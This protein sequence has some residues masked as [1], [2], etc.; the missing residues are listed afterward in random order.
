MAPQVTSAVSPFARLRAAAD[1]GGRFLRFGQGAKEGD[2][3]WALRMH[4]RYTRIVHDDRGKMRC[5]LV[6]M[7]SGK[8][9]SEDLGFWAMDVSMRGRNSAHA[10]GFLAVLGGVVANFARFDVSDTFSLSAVLAGSLCEAAAVIFLY[11]SATLNATRARVARAH[12]IESFPIGKII[13]K[14]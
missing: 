8:R 9:V 1:R 14:T 4:T 5:G 2:H 3:A 6:G 11:H 12:E 7:K 13:D 10:G